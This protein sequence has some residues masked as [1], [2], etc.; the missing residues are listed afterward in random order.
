MADKLKIMV[1]STIYG[2][3]DQLEIIC[4]LIDSFGH[5][6]VMNSH[7]KT[8]PVYPHLSAQDTCLAAVAECDL[9]FG[10]IRPRY[11]AVV[12]EPYSITHREITKS[13]ELRK[14]RWLICHRDIIVARQLL[15]QYMYN[16]DESPNLAFS[17]KKTIL[18]DDIRLVDMYNEATMDDIPPEDRVGHWVD[19]FYRLDDIKKCVI[20]NFSDIHRV[21]LIID[22]MKGK[23]DE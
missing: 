9:F 5:Y 6:Q 15:K 3:Q 17:Y 2:F 16:A 11:G 1:A 12:E 4:N 22:Q 19:E 10:I 18:M 8:L 20:T 14:P 7:M 23:I 21:K 13:I